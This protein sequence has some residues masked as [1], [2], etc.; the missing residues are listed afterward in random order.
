MIYGCGVWDMNVDTIAVGCGVT[1]SDI[2]QL[3]TL[4]LVHISPYHANIILYI[5]FDTMTDQ[6]G[7]LLPSDDHI[8]HRLI[9]YL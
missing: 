8:Y 1:E 5:I 3:F 7:Y 6:Y 2:D 4:Q 9:T